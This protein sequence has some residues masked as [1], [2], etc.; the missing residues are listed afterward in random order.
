[1]ANG[2]KPVGYFID[3]GTRMIKILLEYRLKWFN[4]SL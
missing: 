2:F 1:M 3:E 4:L